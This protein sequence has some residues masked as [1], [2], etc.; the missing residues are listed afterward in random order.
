M[1]PVTH[2]NNYRGI[3]EDLTELPRED[4]DFWERN[5]ILTQVAQGGCEVSVLGDIQN[6]MGCRPEQPVV[7]YPAFGCG[8][9]YMISRSTSQLQL[10]SFKKCWEYF[11]LIGIIKQ[12]D[13]HCLSWWSLLLILSF[14]FICIKNLNFINLSGIAFSIPVIPVAFLRTFELVLQKYI[15]YV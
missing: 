3:S 15:K 5:Q 14:F 4:A 10:F 12:G 8:L 1:V 2:W 6:I 7:D 11:Q 9:D 13:F